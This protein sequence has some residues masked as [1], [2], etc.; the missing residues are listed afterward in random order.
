M[1]GVS[2]FLQQLMHCRLRLHSYLA[3]LVCGMKAVVKA[4]PFDRNPRRSHLTQLAANQ[5]HELDIRV[6]V[7]SESD[8]P[9][10]LVLG[11]GK[12]LKTHFFSFDST[13]KE[14][15][16]TVQPIVINSIQV[17]LFSCPATCHQCGVA[18]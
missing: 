1:L 3:Q 17:E 16:G 13:A 18:S 10:E 12:P 4:L 14:C 5:A 7:H 2:G 11:T 9:F 8:L 15:D 6:K